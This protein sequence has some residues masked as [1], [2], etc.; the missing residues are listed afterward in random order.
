MTFSKG[1]YSY[2]KHLSKSN[3]LHF[4]HHRCELKLVNNVTSSI[5]FLQESIRKEKVFASKFCIHIVPETTS[6]KY[7]NYFDFFQYL[8]FY[9]KHNLTYNPNVGPAFYAYISEV[10]TEVFTTIEKFD[11]P[12]GTHK[13]WLIT[14][15]IFLSIQM[16]E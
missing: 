15:F 12:Q 6:F 9:L 4:Y 3:T 7:Y 5:R 8:K 13:R 1:K 10:D 11:D 2:L 16:G 14:R